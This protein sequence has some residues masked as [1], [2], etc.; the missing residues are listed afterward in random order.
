METQAISVK[1][2]RENFPS[3]R[4]GLEN[5]LLYLLIYRSKP[6][7]EIRPLAEK[8]RGNRVLQILANPPKNLCFTS[9]LSSVELVRR[10]RD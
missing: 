9:K 3:V 10:Q 8:K 6:I 4:K 1:N 5:G 2:L 7:A